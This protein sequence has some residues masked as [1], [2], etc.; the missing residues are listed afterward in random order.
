MKRIDIIIAIANPRLRLELVGTLDARKVATT[1]VRDLADLLGLLDERSNDE[2]RTH[3]VLIMEEAFI[4]PHVYEECALIKADS[5]QPLKIVL[6][7]EPRTRTR[8]DWRGVDHIL[9]LPMPA[10]EIATRTLDALSAEL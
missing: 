2:D 4:Y 10:R 5:P 8:S 1:V 3:S 7:V 9:R 6:L